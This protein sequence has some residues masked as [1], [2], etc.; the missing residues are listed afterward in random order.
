MNQRSA[1]ITLD[2]QPEYASTTIDGQPVHGTSYELEGGTKIVKIRV[3][4][5]GFFNKAYTIKIASDDIVRIRLE[6]S[7]TV[8]HEEEGAEASPREFKILYSNVGSAVR[9]H[10][11]DLD[12]KA[13]ADLKKRYDAINFGDAMEQPE[14]RASA[15]RSLREIKRDFQ[16]ALKQQERK[17][18]KN[19]SGDSVSHTPIERRNE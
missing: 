1:R 3:S 18:R 6:P 8:P 4:F 19:A 15:M 17:R 14:L 10:R 9:S 7:T 12:T 11:D 16:V 13:S 2:V 5:R